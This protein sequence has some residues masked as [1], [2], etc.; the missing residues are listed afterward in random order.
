[1]KSLTR[2]QWQ[3]FIDAGEF[4]SEEL[5]EATIQTLFLQLE[6]TN[7]ALQSVLASVPVRDADEIISANEKFLG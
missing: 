3:E 5:V 4:A 7:K 6:H 1:M 2:S